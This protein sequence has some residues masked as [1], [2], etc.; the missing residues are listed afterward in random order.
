[1]ALAENFAYSSTSLQVLK[2]FSTFCAVL[3]I[4]TVIKLNKKEP[5]LMNLLHENIFYFNLKKQKK[6]CFLAYYVYKLIPLMKVFHCM[7]IINILN[8]LGIRHSIC[9]KRTDSLNLKGIF[10]VS[11]VLLK[12]ACL[13]KFTT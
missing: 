7:R 1:M 4:F 9:T 12:N 6:D 13:F 10:N 8:W 5:Q 2:I 11:R 3:Q